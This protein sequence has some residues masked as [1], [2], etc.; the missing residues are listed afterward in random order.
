MRS[1]YGKGPVLDF[2]A[3]FRGKGGYLTLE[4]LFELEIEIREIYWHI[5]ENLF[6]PKSPEICNT[7]GDPISF[8]RLIYDLYDI[9]PVVARLA[10]LNFIETAEEILRGAERDS[11]GKILKVEFDW[12]KKGNKQVKEWDNTMLGRLIFE[13][14]R[15]TIEVN[16]AKRANTIRKKVERL[17]GQLVRYKTTLIEPL[18]AKIKERRSGKSKVLDEEK[19]RNEELNNRPEIKAAL[20]EFTRKHMEGWIYT[21]IPP[22]NGRT[23]MEAVKDPEGKEMV[24][25]LLTQF[26]RLAMN[27]N[28]VDFELALLKETRGKL[29]LEN[30]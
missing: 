7:D 8:H 22:L 5:K 13:G 26:E 16:S 21:K 3:H 23:P 28:D 25:A 19:A 17:A 2:R 24:L 27:K 29:G 6:N 12:I 30:A 14:S 20:R 10:T 4:D 1:I 18:E 9:E 11:N 15:L